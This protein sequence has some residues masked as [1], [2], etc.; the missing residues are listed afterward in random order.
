[1]NGEKER[2]AKL[3]I[4]IIVPMNIKHTQPSSWLFTQNNTVL[5]LHQ[6]VHLL[7]LNMYYAFVYNTCPRIY[8]Y[9]LTMI[10]RDGA[11]IE[12][13]CSVLFAVRVFAKAARELKW[14]KFSG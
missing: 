9:S 6:Q 8:S 4:C 1:M 13:T 12:K 3:L 10:N 11:Y 7:Y 14:L 2:L 5:P